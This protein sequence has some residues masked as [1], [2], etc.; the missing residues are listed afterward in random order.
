MAFFIRRT[1]SLFAFMNTIP[2]VKFNVTSVLTDLGFEL[3]HLPNLLN[4][5]QFPKDH[6]PYKPHRI[7]FFA[8]LMITEGK[9]THQLDFKE[10]TL[11]K[12]DCLIISKD[13]VHAFNPNCNYNGSI[14][15]FTETFLLNHFSKSSIPKISRL[16]NYHLNSP[17]YSHVKAN[18]KFLQVIKTELESDIDFVKAS[19]LGAYLT[20]YLLKLERFNQQK[21]INYSFD[22][23]YDIFTKFKHEVEKQYSKHRNAKK[24]AEFL[25]ISYKLLNKVSKRF[26]GKTAKAYIDDY[27]VLEAKRFLTYTNMSVKE[28]SY[29]CGFD[30]PT[31]F[32]K[33]FKNIVGITP[34]KFMQKIVNG[35]FLP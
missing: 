9:V 11:E 5:K 10:Y 1:S 27:I 25:A 31:N 14:V 7:R 34:K 23:E 28:V 17:K 30:E 13:Q 22:R 8:I 19:I 3:V 2:E 15:I 20:T 4:P 6:S 35:E 29:L 21:T 12:G 32:S 16:Y 18:E 26:T 24:Y 33:Y